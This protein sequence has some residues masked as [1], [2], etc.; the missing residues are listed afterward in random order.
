[1][2]R[3]IYRVT[4]QVQGV[5]FRPF[6]YREATAL[7]LTGSVGNT[8]EGVRIEVQ[9]EEFQLEEFSHFTERL[10]PLARITSLAVCQTET[11][12]LERD[13]LI[14]TSMKEGHGGQHVLVSPDMAPCEDCLADMADPKNRRFGYA[15][16][17]CTNCGPR[18]TITASIPYDRAVT[19][20]ACFALCPLCEREYHTPG[21]R[22][23]H[24]QPNACPECGPVLWLE[25]Q[26][27]ENACTEE[28]IGMLQRMAMHGRIRSHGGER[29]QLYGLQNGSVAGSSAVPAL[30]AELRRG[31]IAAIRGLG[32]FHLACDAQNAAAV[33]KLRFRKA[34]PHKALAIMVADMAAARRFAEIGSSA[35]KLLSSARRP[36]VICPRKKGTLPSILSPDTEDIGIMLPS[37]PLHHLLFHP[38]WAGGSREDSLSALVMTS[39]N[40]YGSPLCLGNRE[41]KKRLS[42]IADVF[43]FHDRDIL[44]RID[45][46]VVFPE[47]EKKNGQPSAPALMVRRARGFVPEPMLLPG[48][49]G[50]SSSDSVFAAGAELKHTFCLTRG[51]DAFLSQH[52]GDVTHPENLEFFKKTLKHLINLLEVEPRLVVRDMHPDFLSSQV[53]G[54]F[55]REHD[56]Q[57]VALQHHA[58]HVCAVMAEHRRSTPVLGLVLDG[59]GLGD[60]GSI[61]GGELLEVR[62]G[63]WKRRGRF[64]PFSLPGGEAAIRSPWRTAQSLWREGGLPGDDFPWRERYAGTA[65]MVD[66]MLKKNIRCVLTSSCGRLFDAVSALCGLCF[67]ITYE[68]QAA[69]RLEHAQDM[70]ETGSYE[71]PVREK[72]GLLEADVAAL[73]RAA[74]EDRKNPSVLARRFHRTLAAGLARWVCMAAEKTGIREVA[75]CGG[76][77]NNRTLLAELPEELERLGITPLLPRLVPAGDGAISLGQALWGDWFLGTGEAAE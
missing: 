35:Q 25:R 49:Y 32:G 60:D 16:T 42:S 73:F 50:R 4:G 8:P 2:P 76:V 9:G 6:I 3:H 67:D 18:Y 45:D 70:R 58:A 34:R 29:L 39:G 74:A 14:L 52:I 55:A 20:M 75:L 37:T 69:I 21:E 47:K 64:S 22:R 33:E 54:E 56:I 77:F 23:F 51:Q 72:D 27:E 10:P 57:E 44:V 43:L 38:E 65:P 36:I 31:R 17:N 46:S 62:P 53:A 40:A 7:G 5:G 61:W 12:P 30:L 59:S 63:A 24:A 71:L 1:M 11:I 13:F 48:R 66:E 19:S 26:G 68:G 15:F 41:A 28:R